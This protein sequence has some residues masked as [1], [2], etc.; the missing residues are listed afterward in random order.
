MIP[1]V[2][3][4]YNQPQFQMVAVELKKEFYPRAELVQVS[5]KRSSDDEPIVTKYY[6]R[7]SIFDWNTVYNASRILTISHGG[8]DGP[9]FAYDSRTIGGIAWGRGLQPWA[10]LDLMSPGTLSQEG[11]AFWKRLGLRMQA[12][13]KIIFLGCNIAAAS[14]ARNVSRI[15]GGKHVYASSHTFGAGDIQKVVPQIRNIEAKAR[16]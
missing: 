1:A 3:T 9:I 8:L 14:F 5:M 13:G 2:G 10:E 6:A 16:S 12:D 4:G 7:G 15:S 11:K